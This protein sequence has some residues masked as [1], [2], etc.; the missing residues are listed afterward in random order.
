M[1]DASENHDLIGIALS[2]Q[3]DHS[4]CHSALQ[5]NVTSCDV[6]L[7]WERPVGA[8]RVVEDEDT[9]EVTVHRRQVLRIATKIQI[10]MLKTGNM[11]IQ[12][13]S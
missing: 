4:S 2:E 12:I 13:Y 10:A 11:D 3:R 1:S 6:I 8:W 7:T 9:G 5:R